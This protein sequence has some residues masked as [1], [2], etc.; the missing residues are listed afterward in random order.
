MEPESANHTVDMGTGWFVYY[1]DI[2]YG[3]SQ[4]PGTT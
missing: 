2:V 3:S 1:Y 4:S